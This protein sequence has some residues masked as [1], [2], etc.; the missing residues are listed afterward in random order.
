[1]VNFVLSYVE[2]HNCEL[3]IKNCSFYISTADTKLYNIVH[4][5]Y[6]EITDNPIWIF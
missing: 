5:W 1:M 6:D 4:R 2:Y 3:A